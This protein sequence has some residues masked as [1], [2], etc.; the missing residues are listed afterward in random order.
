MAEEVDIQY[1]LA[2]ST[3]TSNNRLEASEAKSPSYDV[4]KHH[5]KIYCLAT[6]PS[7]P[8]PGILL[9]GPVALHTKRAK[10]SLT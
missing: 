1:S 7:A 6:S 2:S 10:F 5:E 9:S 8:S 3:S 4:K